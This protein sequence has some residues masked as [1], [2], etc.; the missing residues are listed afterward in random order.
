MLGH[1]QKRDD[2]HVENRRY[3]FYH[4]DAGGGFARFPARDGLSCDVEFFRKVLLGQSTLGTQARKHVFQKHGESFQRCQFHRPLLSTPRHDPTSNRS[5]RR[6]H[7]APTAAR[8]DVRSGSFADVSCDSQRRPACAPPRSATPLAVGTAERRHR[9]RLRD[10]SDSPLS[11]V[12]PEISTQTCHPP[13]S[14]RFAARTS[15]ARRDA[16]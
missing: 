9:Y 13:L 1:V 5:L 15:A 4:V 12:M 11:A 16:R 7:D 3:Q 2:R 10:S 14:D 6:D 8:A